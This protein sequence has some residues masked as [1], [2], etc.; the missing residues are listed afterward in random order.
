MK[1]LLLAIMLLALLFASNDLAAGQGTRFTVEVATV[2]NVVDGDTIDVR[3]LDVNQTSQRVRYIGINTP[4]VDQPC[5]GEATAA[6]AALVEGKPITMLKDVSETDQYGRL[7]RYVYVGTTFVNAALVA[8]GWAEAAEYPPDT[9]FAEWFSLLEAQASDGGL[10]CWPTGVFKRTAPAATPTLAAAN[11]VT[12]TASNSV[13][14]RSGPGQDYPVAGTLAAGQTKQ[15]VGRNGDWLYLADGTW[16]AAWVVTV[17]G[18]IN[19][20]P[21][22]SAPPPPAAAAPQQPAAQSQAPAAQPPAAQPAQPP[23]PAFTCDCNKSC[24]AMA[25]CEE[26]YFQLQQCGCGRRDG[27]NDGVPCE[28]ICP[29]G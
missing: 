3:L 17:S 14:L 9:A 5:S 2:T 23:A 11:G 8:D 1:R 16:V 22:Q 4:E 27:D 24:S 6:N 18:S 26:A 7:L 20:L 29:G 10:G 15:A 19:T 25:S 21:T 28:D 12:V 13:N